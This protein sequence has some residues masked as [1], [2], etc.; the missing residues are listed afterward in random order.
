MLRPVA[1]LLQG[2]CCDQRRWCYKAT[3][4]ATTMLQGGGV[5]CCKAV[6]LVVLP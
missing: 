4:P 6:R 3:P 2:G 5:W 1:V